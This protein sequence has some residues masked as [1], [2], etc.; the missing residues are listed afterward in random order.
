MPQM[1]ITTPSV[2]SFPFRSEPA[3]DQ[4]GQI[5]KEDACYC[6]FI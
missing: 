3:K 5:P 2:L 4:L 1:K 6:L